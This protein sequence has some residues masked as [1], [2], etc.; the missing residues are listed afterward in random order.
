MPA[1][2]YYVNP[3]DQ[4]LV[5]VLW[6][7]REWA[8]VLTYSRR[9]SFT[10]CAQRW[11][12][13][14]LDGLRPPTEPVPLTLGK[15]VH[16]GLAA[17]YARLNDSTNITECVKAAAAEIALWA[18]QNASDGMDPQKVQELG[19][20]A[21]HL[22]ERTV[23]RYYEH[24]RQELE[25]VAIEVPWRAPLPM[26][27]GRTLSRWDLAGVI[28]LVA[29]FR[30]G[31]MAGH[32]Q[33]FDHKT[34]A[35]SS[36]SRDRYASDLNADTQRIGYCWGVQG[37]LDALGLDGKRLTAHGVCYNVVR[38]REIREP[39]LNQCPKCKGAGCPVCHQTGKGTVSKTVTDTTPDA[40]YALRVTHPHID[41]ADYQAH[42]DALA[43]RPESFNFREHLWCDPADY[44]RWLAECY[45]VS[46]QMSE[47]VA[48]HR[49][50][51][52]R[53][54]CVPLAGSP[55]SF[56][57]IC[58]EDCE[59]S[60]SPFRHVVPVGLKGAAEMRVDEPDEDVTDDLAMPF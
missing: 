48:R 41:P 60:R 16:R 25:V 8:N 22:C 29:R 12:Y 30:T 50:L 21:A 53:R 46:R 35:G 23:R 43:A 45:D 42:I 28:D 1:P 59:A 31:P 38:K 14:D 18:F 20:F 11:A 57:A 47:S 3:P 10:S 44:P 34:W 24:D 19:D 17:A 40:Y 15:L 36:N 27:G 39:A 2:S 54:E 4:P 51:R 49:F 32:L 26:P 9:N 55:C 5:R 13:F 56:R 37:A 33:V 7:G 58:Q 52:N 6:R